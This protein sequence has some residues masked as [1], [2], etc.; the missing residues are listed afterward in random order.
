MKIKVIIVD[1]EM[2]ARSFLRKFCERY[3]SETI[4]VVEEC[5]SVEAAVRAIKKYQPDL[6]FLDIQMPDE[7]G[8][9]F[10]KYFDKINFEII[11]TTAYKEY[12]IEAIK[13]SALDY[14]VKPFSKEDF[15]IALSRFMSK[16]NVKIDFDRFKLLTE[17]I[18]N[19][20][21]DKQ[22]IVFPTKSGF[23]VIQANSIV[24]C[25][26]DGSYSNIFIIDKELFTSKSLKE[27]EDILVDSNFIR[28]HKSYIVNKNYIKGFKS[29]EFKL[30]LI[31]GDSIPVSDTLFSKKK[32]MD[33]ISS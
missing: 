10:L 21:T 23:E 25:K 5:N 29:D 3:H 14:L 16:K 15:N 32:L 27:I 9:E 33:A 13:K 12:A 18:N 19:Q 1:D 2:H 24:Y 31:T 17:N 7:N 8:F 26:S 30:D 28:I 4:E 6:V 11:F 22:R 20:F